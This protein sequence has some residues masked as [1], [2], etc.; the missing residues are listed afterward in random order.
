MK[1]VTCTKLQVKRMNCP[2]D[3][4]PPLSRLRVT[5]FSSRLLGLKKTAKVIIKA[6]TTESVCTF[7][8]FTR[9]RVYRINFNICWSSK[10]W[11]KRTLGGGGGSIG[12]N[13]SY[14]DTI[15]LGRVVQS[16]ICINPWWDLKRN[17]RVNPGLALLV[18]VVMQE[19]WSMSRR[20]GLEQYS[21]TGILPISSC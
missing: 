1:L 21:V 8:Y 10:T 15:H 5:I 6:K 12:P 14:F 16:P 20:G 4:P 2:I 19:S 18:E 13:H 3:P 7:Y 11:T 9:V 17:C